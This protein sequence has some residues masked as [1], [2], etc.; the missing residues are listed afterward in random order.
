MAVPGYLVALDTQLVTW[1]RTKAE[2]TP[3]G[4]LKSRMTWPRRN[5][6][7]LQR[8]TETKF[9]RRSELSRFI[10]KRGFMESAASVRHERF[11]FCALDERHRKGTLSLQTEGQKPDRTWV[12]GLGATSAAVL[13]NR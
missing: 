2:Y 8:E 1:G 4:L 13:D 7:E 9:W 11:A 3:T 10:S 12:S 6:G 5:G